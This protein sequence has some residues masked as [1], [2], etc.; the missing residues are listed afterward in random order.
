MSIEIDFIR[1]VIKGPN[2]VALPAGEPRVRTL[3]AR[4]IRHGWVRF[5]RE[6]NLETADGISVERDV[7]SSF[8]VARFARDPEFRDLRIPCVSLDKTRLALRDVA[9]H[10]GAIPRPN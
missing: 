3:Q 4:R 8:A 2:A 5:R 10:T 6:M 7:L 9:V 1:H